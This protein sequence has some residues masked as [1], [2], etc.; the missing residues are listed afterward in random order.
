MQMYFFFRYSTGPFEGIAYCV[1]VAECGD[2]SREQVHISQKWV[3]T[4][5]WS[6]LNIG[7]EA[8]RAVP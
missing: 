1:R 4:G 8:G 6:D 2:N 5:C 7:R 3:F